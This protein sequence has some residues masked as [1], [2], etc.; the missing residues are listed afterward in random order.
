MWVYDK[1]TEYPINIKR[2]DPRMAKL[3]LTQYGGPNGELAASLRYLS[4]RYA[5]PNK[6]SKAILTDIGTEELAHFEMVGSM[7][8]QLVKDVPPQ[9]LER[10]GFG[11][12][13]A[14]HGKGVYPSDSN[15]VPFT[16]AYIESMSDPIANLNEDLAAEQKARATYEFLINMADDPDVIDPL[17]FLREREVVHYQRFGEALRIVYE[18]MRR[19]KMYYKPNVPLVGMADK[20]DMPD[21]KDMSDKMNIMPNPMN[22]NP[23]SPLNIHNIPGPIMPNTKPDSKKK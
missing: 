21:K 5:M 13:Y 11:S 16:A 7:I 1:K 18:A 23:V 12:V 2:P 19:K 9:E 20:K 10:M 4:Q 3:I 8:S 14:I 6:E 22:P 15:G 17:R